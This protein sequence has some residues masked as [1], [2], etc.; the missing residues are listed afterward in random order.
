LYNTFR[1]Q[2]I[3]TQTFKETAAD[4]TVTVTTRT[5]T[6]YEGGVR[7]G[8]LQPLYVTLTFKCFLDLT[9]CLSYDH[10]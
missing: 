4:G 2:D 5:T 1:K 8:L 3:K 7:V 10:N 6:T 9:W